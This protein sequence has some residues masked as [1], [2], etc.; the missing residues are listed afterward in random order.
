MAARQD[1]TLVIVNILC[2]VLFLAFA[3]LAYV[4]LKGRSD[5]R[6]ELTGVRTQLS[7][8]EQR[9]RTLLDEVAQ[10]RGMMG[11]GDDNISAVTEGF[12]ADK[13][14]YSA[15]E[16]PTTSY[17]TM[18]KETHALLQSTE[19]SEAAAKAE[20]ADLTVRLK[21]VETEADLRIKEAEKARSD[22]QTAAADQLNQF[23]RDRESLESTKRELLTTLDQQKNAYETS[24]QQLE[25]QVKQFQEEVDK[26]KKTIVG[27][28]DRLKPADSSFDVADGNIIWVNQGGM[29]WIDLGR[30]DAL[31]EL[32]TFSVFDADEHDTARSAQKGTIEV[33]MVLNDHQAE[34]R[35][36]SVDPRNPMK[37]GDRIYS[38]AWQRGKPLHVAL[39]GII[40]VDGDRQSDVQLV[41][42]L[43]ALNGGVVDA[44][45]GDDGKVEGVM[46]VNTRYLIRGRLPEGVVWADHL[47][48]WQELNKEAV[49]LGVQIVSLDQFL[50]QMGYVP[51]S[52]TVRLGEGAAARDFP[53]QQYSETPASGAAGLP[54]RFRP[55]TP[56]GVPV[57]VPR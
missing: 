47:A 52:R 14:A 2:I 36:T 34:A 6:Q 10:M 56:D 22:A 49:S 4:G 32:V 42:D 50:D 28:Q 29:A 1:Q 43:V 33:T 17:R 7:G 12:D 23:N 39:T 8:A 55:R 31:R 41:R 38:P 15:G 45:V 48:G 13:K 16:D 9:A 54:Q 40:D 25:E 30:A 46:S 44:Y 19:A 18:L 5:A 27:L 57:P 3:V 35:I 21:A 37:K 11:F 20:I 53:P 51:D 26:L 24:I